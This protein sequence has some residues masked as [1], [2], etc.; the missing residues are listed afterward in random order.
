MSG[1]TIFPKRTR[2]IPPHLDLVPMIDTILTLLLFFAVAI[3]LVVG[4]AAMSV[5]LPSAQ[6]SEPVSERVILMLAPGQ[7]VQVNGTPV[8][9]KQLGTELK[10]AANGNLDTQVVVMADSKVQYSQLVSAIDEVRLADFT[11]IALATS[12]KRPIQ[13]S[14]PVVR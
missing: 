1:D 8:D 4:R 5:H 6:T 2:R 12:P 9:I 13:H 14:A 11:R 3:M 7:P 10:R